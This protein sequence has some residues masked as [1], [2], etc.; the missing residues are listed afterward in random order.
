MMDKGICCVVDQF[1][2]AAANFEPR[3]YVKTK[4]FACGDFVCRKC[5]SKRRYYE[6]GLVRLCNNCQVDFDGNRARVMNRLYRLAGYRRY[7]PL[8][9]A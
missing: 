2:L 9:A 6:Y 5:S 4:C 3:I 8:G 7:A 1:C